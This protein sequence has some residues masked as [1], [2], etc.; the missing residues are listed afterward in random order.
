MYLTNISVAHISK[1]VAS[2]KTS[3]DRQNTML[4]MKRLKKILIFTGALIALFVLIYL[5]IFWTTKYWFSDNYKFGQYTLYTNSKFDNSSEFLEKIDQRLRAC[6][7]YDE[8]LEHNIYLFSSERKFK[9]YATVAGSGY[10]A[11][12]FNMNAFNKIYISRP[13]IEQVHSDRKSAN[14]IVPYSAMEGNIEETICHEIIHSFVYNKIGSKRASS[15]PTWKQE[16]YAEYAA[17]LLPKSID[18]TYNFKN[19]V[20]L[21]KDTSFWEGN[22]FI[23]EYY[24]AEILVEFLIDIKKMTFDQLMADTFTYDIAVKELNEYKF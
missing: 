11:Q 13:F 15:L 8:K 17:N 5:S 9:F 1:L 3:S 6:E 18:T 16:G 7:L 21:Y 2:L 14:K 22:Q 23:F 4:K 24:E 10:P 20:E 19:R 12:G